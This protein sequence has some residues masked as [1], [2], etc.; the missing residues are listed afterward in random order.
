[1]IPR[2]LAVIL[3][4]SLSCQDPELI[5]TPLRTIDDLLFTTV[6]FKLPLW[7]CAQI[8]ILAVMS[9]TGRA[10]RLRAK[11]MDRALIIS[12]I[13]MALW[14]VIG[15][16]RGG[17]GMDA[18]F[19]MFTYL[20]AILFAFTL[21]A[22]LKTPEDFAP[23]LD[24]I[25]A[26][27]AYRSLLAIFLYVFVAPGVPPDKLPNSM[28]GHHDS[29]LFV[30]GLVIVLAGAIGR[31]TPGAWRRVW[32]LAPL[33]L[34]AMQ[35]NNRRLA[36]VSLVGGLLAMYAA[37]PAS[38]DQRR[39]TRVAAR[40]VPVIAL[41]VCIG[42]GRPE[43]MFKPLAAFASVSSAEDLST[44][45]RD[46]EN[47]GLIYTLSQSGYLGAL[48]T[49]LGIPYIETDSSLSARSFLQYRII[50]HNS[51]LGL[52]AFTGWLGFAG[53]LLPIPISVFLNARTCRAAAKPA[54]RLSAVVG[55]AQ[56]AI[57]LNQLYGD[58]GMIS[59][60]TL[61]ILATAFA[62]AGRLSAWSGAWPG[63]ARPAPTPALD[64][65]RQ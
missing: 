12:L 59:R 41:Y 60:T 14:Y 26:A 8:V 65:G 51:I 61:T 15:V 24:A 4:L 27:A 52:L 33:F 36:W 16:T 45:S 63:R 3:F 44:K 19:Q 6:W 18:T 46:N 53:I 30:T 13:S 48:G 21:M 56:V 17:V 54:A 35:V 39:F 57:V 62:A 28:T 20:N 43:P 37:V 64:P 25:V 22:L 1:V 9:G 38:R 7:T 2:I 23:L 58:M 47:E 34:V 55:V 50:P 40:V 49:G 42:W 31:V 11:P 29:A 10:P 32:L 5:E